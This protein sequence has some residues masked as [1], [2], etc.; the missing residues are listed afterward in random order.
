[1]PT[2]GQSHSSAPKRARFHLS[3]RSFLIISS[4]FEEH[5]R[6]LKEVSICLKRANLTIGMRKSQFSFQELKYLGF[7][8]GQGKLKTDP[9][10]IKAIKDIKIPRNP[11]EVRS[12]LG[13]AGWYH[14][15]IKDFATISAPLTDSLKKSKKFEISEE[16]AKAF[17]KLK[18]ALTTA[19]VLRHPDFTKH[20]FIQCDASEYGIGAVLYQ[21]NDNLE[22]QPIAFY[23]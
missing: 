8:I 10:K 21:L 5:L 3:R 2:Y 20:F 4:D 23:S 15:F 9:D 14:R 22:E 17:E 12:F 1:M 11:R 19:P 7:I 18:R 6:L 16:G 13:T